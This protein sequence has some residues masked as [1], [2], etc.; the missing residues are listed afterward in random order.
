MQTSDREAFDK[1]SRQLCMGCGAMPNPERLES[2]WS[3]FRKL[4]LVEW[5]RMVEAAMGE[6]GIEKLSVQAMWALRK[7]GRSQ[8]ESVERDKAKADT[9]P[10]CLEYFANRIL[11]QHVRARCGLGSKGQFVPGYGMRDC[12][13]SPELAAC[14]Q[15]RRE[16]VDI[17]TGLAL[18]HDPDATAAK[19]VAA[20]V[21]R[22]KAIGEVKENTLEAYREFCRAESSK[23]PFTAAFVRKVA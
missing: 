15:A 1:L 4:S 6:D 17:F 19:F 7:K 8:A 22:L 12:T 16:L 5:T 3:A 18:E 21:R 10:D 13:P 20:W 9:D 23:R 14:L 2:F 11:W